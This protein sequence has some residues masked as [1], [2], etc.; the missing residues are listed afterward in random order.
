MN[1]VPPLE[2][3]RIVSSY[4]EEQKRGERNAILRKALSQMT[5]EDDLPQNSNYGIFDNG[6]LYLSYLLYDL[7]K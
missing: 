6:L 4:K 3:N 2:Q 5:K 1:Y 7:D